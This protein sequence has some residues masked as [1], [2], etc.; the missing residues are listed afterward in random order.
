MRKFLITF[1]ETDNFSPSPAWVEQSIIH[2]LTSENL[3]LIK[4]WDLLDR[5]KFEIKEVSEQ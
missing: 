3:G 5:H 1:E 2:R 4:A